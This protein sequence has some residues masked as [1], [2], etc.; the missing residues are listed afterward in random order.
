MPP[1][2]D[3]RDA[4]ALAMSSL[5]FHFCPRCGCVVFW[6]GLRTDH[7]GRRRIAV[8]L[9]L[10]EPNAVA[11]IPI[12]HLDRFDTFEDRPCDGRCVANSWF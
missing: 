6:R 1:W 5:A 7:D 2:S 12:D 11:C 8:N 4:I 9:R 3:D 10:A